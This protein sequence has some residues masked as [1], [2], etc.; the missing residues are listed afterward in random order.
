MIDQKTGMRAFAELLEEIESTVNPNE[1]KEF[2]INYLHSACEK[3]KLWMIYLLSGRK[4]K[5]N[6]TAQLLKQW[7]VEASGLPQWLFDESLAFTGDLAETISLIMTH[8]GS[9]SDYTLTDIIGIINNHR[10][11]EISDMKES[12]ADLW[13][14]LDKRE[15]FA[16]NRLI[17][18]GFRTCVSSKVLINAIA[19]CESAD[20]DII[21]YR[22]SQKWDPQ[23]TTYSQLIAGAED[24]TDPC[25]PYSFCF[26][27]AIEGE[28]NLSGECKEWAAEWKWDGM[29]AQLIRRDSQFFVWSRSGE[30]LTEMFPE[31]EVSLSYLP[32]GLVLDGEI[33]CYG[34]GMPMSF[35]ALQK[36]I[37]RKYLTS[38][39]K[40]EAPAVF[41]AFDVIEFQSNDI[42]SKPFHERRLLL[43]QL[44][45]DKH[46]GDVI[47]LSPTISFS[48][49]DE[50]KSIRNLSHK[51]GAHGLMLKKKDSDY[52]SGRA[53]GN[54]WKWKVD[55]MI[56]NAV[57]IYAQSGHDRRSGVNSVYTFGVWYEDTLVPIAKAHSGL[58]DIVKAE[59]D[60]FVVENTLEK[61]GP[62]RTVNPELVFEIA[63]EGITESARHKSGIALRYP[64]ISRWRKD[65]KASDAD[66][67]L[68][69]KKL[70]LK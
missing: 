27:N 42:R 23:S 25:K 7:A 12:V 51:I 29:R 40:K 2:I 61:F 67:I 5:K 21:T 4:V 46:E 20:P 9:R 64:R 37:N 70:L 57:L 11:D 45:C 62:V 53:Q 1:K 15:L 36:R 10:E 43:E 28:I 52:S 34:N 32:D 14:V 33:I 30:I 60:R 63:F 13:K 55:P 6:L 22:L 47:K 66:S 35:N 18:R 24:K 59:V 3:D 8:E 39:M 65:K 31:L 26:A 41:V 56:V 50:L 54:W 17:T 19:E 38:K 69:L 68:T 58:E 48:E 49:W 44:L 16:F